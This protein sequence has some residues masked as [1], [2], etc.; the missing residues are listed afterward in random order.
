MTDTPVYKLYGKTGWASS[1]GE[2]D[3]DKATRDI[4]WFVGYVEKDGNV[5]FFAT[6]VEHPAPVPDTFIPGRR[7]ITEK[8]LAELKLI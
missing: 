4:G 1:G 5:Y 6:N 8:I 7:R 3:A 2:T